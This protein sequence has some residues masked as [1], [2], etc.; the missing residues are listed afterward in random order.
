MSD[1][2][3]LDAYRFDLP[4]ELI[5][6]RPAATRDGSR[7]LAAGPAGR[8]RH[9]AFREL[10]AELEAGDA[11]VLNHTKVIN[12]RCFAEKEHGGRLELFILDIQVD[13]R[14]TPA[15]VKPAKRVRPGVIVRFPK[16]G[17]TARVAEKLEGGR[18]LLA[19]DD[20]AALNA[21]IEADGELPLPPYIKRQAGPTA[22]DA[23]RYQTVYAREPGAVAAP[24]AG[25]H[26][27]EPLLAELRTMGVEI[28]TIAHHVG[29]G[30]FKPVNVEDVRE[31]RMD[32]E[33]YQISDDTADRLNAVKREGRR[34][35]AVGTTSVRCL[36][37][38]WRDGFHAAN[39]AS[40]LYIYP[41][42]RFQAIDG[43]ITNFHLPGS[44]LMLLVAALMGRERILSIYREAIA[45][46]YRF[47]SYGDAM[48]L[49]P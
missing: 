33:R 44:T 42:Y 28:L 12:A 30:T 20:S 39:E 36:E 46:R 18:A 35:I 38:N 27:T 1:D 6:Q 40:S 48:L 10:A 5:A 15:L 49:L 23:K 32:A 4:S 2:F 29:V 31:H 26:F 9:R 41:G 37:S 22:E 11:L 34:L 3:Q 13:P 7:L 25:L 21:A 47:Y 43:L 14:A 8:L 17:V 24:T 16:S 19:F 45:R